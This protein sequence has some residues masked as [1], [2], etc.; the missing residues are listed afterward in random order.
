[1]N[2][3]ILSFL[4]K[5]L[6]SVF[7]DL[8]EYDVPPMPDGNVI[9]KAS[10]PK[11]DD[12]NIV[13][14]EFGRWRNNETSGTEL[15]FDYDKLK[16]KQDSKARSPELD[17]W[18]IAYLDALHPKHDRAL[19]KIIKLEF[20]TVNEVGDYP[21]NQDITNR[22][23]HDGITGDGFSIANVKKY[24]KCFNDAEKAREQ[25]QELKSRHSPANER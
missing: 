3:S 10:V 23:T 1:M 17:G 2:N 18:D 24:T 9:T 22:H 20:A 4:Q 13:T 7:G 5:L 15:I 12:G 6:P 25:E 19:A 11:D 8:S 16:G 14:D 21:S